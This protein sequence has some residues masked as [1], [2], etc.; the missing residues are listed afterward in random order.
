MRGLTRR[1]ARVSDLTQLSGRMVKQFFGQFMYKFFVWMGFGTAGAAKCTYVYMRKHPLPKGG[2]N[3]TFLLMRLPPSPLSVYGA[4]ARTCICAST[5][6]QKGGTIKHFSFVQ[7]IRIG[8]R[9]RRKCAYVQMRG[10]PLPN[11]ENN[12][13]PLLM[14]TFPL[15]RN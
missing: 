2:N 9:D 1:Q 10:H 11:G 6:C 13:T 15:M 14:R 5:L 8:F 7:F 12:R 3:Q 4:S